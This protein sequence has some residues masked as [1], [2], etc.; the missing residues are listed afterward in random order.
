[1][2]QPNPPTPTITPLTNNRVIN[3]V[4]KRLIQDAEQHVQ[5]T[6]NLHPGTVQAMAALSC[7]MGMAHFQQSNNTQ[8]SEEARKAHRFVAD[9][10]KYLAKKMLLSTG[11]PE[12]H[13]EDLLKQIMRQVVDYE[14]SQKKPPPP[15]LIKP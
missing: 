2:S 5:T 15:S 8:H 1:M 14:R 10:A 13:A 12:A 6:A 7:Q 11:L 4:T 3:D 9:N